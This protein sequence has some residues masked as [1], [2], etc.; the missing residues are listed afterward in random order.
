MRYRPHA[1]FRRTQHQVEFELPN[2]VLYDLLSLLKRLNNSLDN[3]YRLTGDDIFS[4]ALED[5]LNLYIND[6]NGLKK[7]VDG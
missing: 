6:L 4:M 2:D 5:F 1:I 3:G 7:R